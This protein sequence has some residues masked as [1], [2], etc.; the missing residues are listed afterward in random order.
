[1]SR[2]SLAIASLVFLLLATGP[3]SATPSFDEEEVE[4]DLEPPTGAGTLARVRFAATYWFLNASRRPWRGTIAYPIWVAPWQPAPTEVVLEGGQRRPVRCLTPS[5]CATTFE[6]HIAPR[7]RTAVR[8][9]YVQTV[10]VRRGQPW[11]AVYLLTSGAS[12]PQPIGRARLRVVVPVGVR[13]A[14]SYP[15]SALGEVVRRGRRRA[16]YE[17]EQERFVP[18]EELRVGVQPTNSAVLRPKMHSRRATPPAS[19]RRPWPWSPPG[20]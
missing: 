5:Y 2:T 4:L 16:V 12:W 14:L 6:V 13:V 1:M 10:R 19:Q 20:G 11:A 3:A 17:L 8:L 15:A 7:S 9:S 18:R